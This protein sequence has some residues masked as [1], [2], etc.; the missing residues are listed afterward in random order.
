MKQLSSDELN[1]NIGGGA[2]SW[3]MLGASIAAGLVAG[4]IGGISASIMGTALCE[5]LEP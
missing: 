5:Y 2:C 3:W 4:P 1:K